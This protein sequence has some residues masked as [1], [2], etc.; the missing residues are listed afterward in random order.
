MRQYNATEARQNFFSVLDMAIK[1]GEIRIDR[2]DG[3]SFRLT[4]IKTKKSPLD[5]DG[6]S[7]GLSSDD[8]VSLVREG[9]DRQYS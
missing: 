3:V 1:D 7:L 2:R 5:V 9:R 8:L 4:P 6:V